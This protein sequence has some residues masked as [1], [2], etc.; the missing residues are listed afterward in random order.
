MV[1]DFN[2]L[3]KLETFK[4]VKRTLKKTFKNCLQ[5]FSNDNPVPLFKSLIVAWD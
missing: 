4:K 5:P 3:K 2:L 1:K